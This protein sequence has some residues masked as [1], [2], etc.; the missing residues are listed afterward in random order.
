F[1]HQTAAQNYDFRRPKQ[2]G[3]MYSY[4]HQLGYQGGAGGGLTGNGANGGTHCVLAYGGLS[5]TNGGTGGTGNSCYTALNFG[6]FG[7]GGGG[8][9]S[10]PGAGGGYSGGGSAGYWSSHSSYGGGGGSYNNGSS[11]SN[12]SGVQT[13]N[14]QVIITMNVRC[15]PTIAYGGD[16]TLSSATS[17]PSGVDGVDNGDVN[18]SGY[19]LNLSSGSTFAWN[20]GKSITVGTG[21]ITVNSGAQVKQTN[22]WYQTNLDNQLAQDDQPAGYSRRYTYSACQAYCDGKS[23]PS[24]CGTVVGMTIT[25]SYDA[26]YVASYDLGTCLCWCVKPHTSASGE[27]CRL[28]QSCDASSDYT[29]WHTCGYYAEVPSIAGHN[30]AQVKNQLGGN[31]LP[32]VYCGNCDT[33]SYPGCNQIPNGC[34]SSNCHAAA[35]GNARWGFNGCTA[36]TYDNSKVICCAHNQSSPG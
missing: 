25:T 6:G 15:S 22:L 4:R 26:T 5:F 20:T 1:L 21:S 7:G 23:K 16:V 28:V 8:Q 19:N 18:L 11:Q 33:I 12:S 17:C 10:G 3:V 35:Y 31:T 24:S 14:G 30:C 34:H 13:G 32:G 29:R 27:D 2:D 36:G 9:L